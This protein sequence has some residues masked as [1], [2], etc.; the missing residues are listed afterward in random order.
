MLE[1]TRN[2]KCEVCDQPE[3]VGMVESRKG[4][5]FFS[6]C[7]TK[8]C[9]YSET[10]QIYGPPEFDPEPSWINLDIVDLGLQYKKLID[11]PPTPAI[12]DAGGTR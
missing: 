8:D 7:L 3:S 12:L 2:W 9:E 10:I 1:L 11:N 4:P 5:L 6:I